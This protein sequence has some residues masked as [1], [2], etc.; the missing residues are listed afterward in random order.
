MRR[1]SLRQSLPEVGFVF[2]GVVIALLAMRL[3]S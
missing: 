1:S 3:D 2:L